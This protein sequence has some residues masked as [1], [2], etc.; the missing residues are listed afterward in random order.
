M[1]SSPKTSEVTVSICIASYNM[2]DTI[3]ESLKSII[4]NLPPYFEIVI[5]D[6]STDG[7]K[8]IIDDI[9]A[10]SDISFKR[11]YT[12]VPLGVG[13]AR[14]LA[15]CNATG[16]IVITHVDVDDWYK[17]QYFPALV[18]L[19][20]EIK[21]NRGSDFFLSCPN[22]NISS[23]DHIMENYLLSSL[24]IG[25]N[26]K[27]YRWRAYKNGDLLNLNLDEKIS[28][29]IKLSNRKTVKNRVQRTYTRHLGMYDIGYS[30]RRIVEE[31]VILR[32]WPLHS[33]IF[34]TLI[35]P[36]VW[37]HSLTRDELCNAPVDG[38]TLPEAMEESTYNLDE[39]IDKYNVDR[40][41]EVQTIAKQT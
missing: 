17:S 34:R 41:L 12:D 39:V 7:S 19:Y 4:K 33:R 35:L 9:A 2:G 38:K 32:S 30:T 36:F 16:E 28:G 5:V 6:Q 25:A 40:E 27:E 13:H 15:V 1:N 20:L 22:M 21:R 23:R 8:N 11:I 24:P 37:I 29:R 14:N 10:D 31:D 26:E 3:K 18:E